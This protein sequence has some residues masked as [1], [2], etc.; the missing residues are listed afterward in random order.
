VRWFPKITLTFLPPSTLDIP[1]EIRGRKRRELAR[2]TLSDLMRDSAYQAKD[3]RKTLFQA[4]LDAR[5][6]YGR[7]HVI[8][9]DATRK[10]A[11]YGQLIAASL[12][13]GDLFAQTTQ[14]GENV[15]LLIPNSITT[16]ALSFGLSYIGRVPA[17]LNYSAGAK[18]VLS[19]SAAACIKIVVTSRRFV[20]E[21]KFEHLIT[22]LQEGSLKIVWLEDLVSAKIGIY[23]K[24]RAW[25]KELFLSSSCIEGNPD[26]S[27]LILFTSGSESAPKGVVLSHANVVANRNQLISTIDFCPSDIVINAMPMFHI[28]GYVVGTFM[29]LFTGMK[30]FFYPTP[31]H[32]RQIPLVTYDINATIIFGA[33]TFL[34]GYARNANPYDFYNVRYAFAGAEKLRERTRKLWAEKFGIRIIEGYGT[35]EASIISVNAAPLFRIGTVGRLLP[36]MASRL[37]SMPGISE[38]GRFYVKGSNVMLGY[39]KADKPGIIEPPDDGWYDTGDILH[40]DENGFVTIKGRVKR[41]AKA[42]GEMISMVAL[43]EEIERL[44]PGVK[45]A[46][47]V[48]EDERKGEQLVLVTEKQDAARSE[49][50]SFL[51]EVG[52]TEVSIPKK[53]MIFPQL[54]LLGS[55]KTDYPSV[56]E[57]IGKG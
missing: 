33:D 40:I 38:G 2:I 45:H 44:W 23:T 1:K 50:V 10:T 3:D 57:L 5:D 11:N 17:M 28:F 15:G 52:Y 55:G 43:E 7:K 13:L 49:L 21:G 47:V 32:Y 42:G 53:I 31:L 24:L 22:T 27:A 8:V 9:M 46:V 34:N 18:N 19:C 37:E 41:F 4:L 20:K 35:T 25:F 16:A 26:D 6:L 48:T 54:P 36:G 56:A 30:T 51:K 39:L 29:T 12:V 14:K